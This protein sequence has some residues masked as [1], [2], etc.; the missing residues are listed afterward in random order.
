MTSHFITS[1]ITH[2]T[3]NIFLGV[4]RMYDFDQIF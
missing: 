1:E 2:K 4:L 3:S